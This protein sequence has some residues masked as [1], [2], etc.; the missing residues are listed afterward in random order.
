M[1]PTFPPSFVALPTLISTASSST[2]NNT[3][4]IPPFE[5]NDENLRL[6]AEAL[7]KSNSVHRSPSTQFVCSDCRRIV[8]RCDVSVQASLDDNVAYDGKSRL[9]LV[10]LTS[11]DD[12]LNNEDAW[13]SLDS[14]LAD[15]RSQIN[16]TCQKDGYFSIPKMHHV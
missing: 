15:K 11:S 13:L 6:A 9:R 10:S 3:Q 12:G 14:R 1:I 2:S 5:T 7:F 16:Q 8:K 4:T